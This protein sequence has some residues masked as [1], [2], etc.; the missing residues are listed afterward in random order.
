MDR[1]GE[2]K[3]HCHGIGGKYIWGERKMGHSW[4]A[5][6]VSN[7]GHGEGHTPAGHGFSGLL[8][9]SIFP[10]VFVEKADC[11]GVSPGAGIKKRR[12]W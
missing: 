7:V 11:S 10:S 5:R 2:R 4:G 1:E 3:E 6:W 8:W 9:A 12:V